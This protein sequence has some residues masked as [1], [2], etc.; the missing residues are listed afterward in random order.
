MVR[1]IRLPLLVS[2]AL[3]LM[4]TL[5]SIAVGAVANAPFMTY[6]DACEFHL[7]DLAT[8]HSRRLFAPPRVY[9]REIA[10]S[11]RTAANWLWWTAAKSCCSTRAWAAVSANQPQCFPGITSGA[12]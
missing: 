6:G 12:A 8:R 11:R 2:V 5:A 4:L 7:Y 1:S 9:T 10:W 3:L